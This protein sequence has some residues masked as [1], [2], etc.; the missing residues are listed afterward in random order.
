MK[1][2]IAIVGYGVG[3]LLSVSKGLE[4]AGAE[5]EVLENLSSIDRFDG[6][7]LPG[8]GAFK[9]AVEFLGV[10]GVKVLKDFVGEGKPILGICLGMQL[11][12][13]E[14]FEG[15]SRSGGLKLLEGRVVPLKRIG[16]KVPHMGWNLVEPVKPS[17][18]LEGI[19]KAYFYFAHSYI[20]EGCRP[21]IV[22][23]RTF[24]GEWFPSVVES[25]R[26]YGTQ[27]H[28]EKSGF[29]GLK[30]LK[31]FINLLSNRGG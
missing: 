30:L 18:L 4:A 24:Y 17:R 22:A 19:G 13:E 20:V 28:P 11:L 10:E 27:F 15:G 5:V 2:R 16:L 23:A 1:P 7:V 9:P 26:V 3:N 14:S 25:D 31:N 29:N 21:E 8:V 12:F 6:A